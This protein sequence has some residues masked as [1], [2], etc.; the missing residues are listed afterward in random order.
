MHI[1]GRVPVGREGEAE[2]GVGKEED[3]EK[4]REDG[5]E[6]GREEVMEVGKELG[7]E[8]RREEGMEEGREEGRQVGREEGR[9]LGFVWWEERGKGAF[10]ASWVVI[11]CVLKTEATVLLD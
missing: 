8:V 11:T 2:L 10:D 5:R 6:E 9:E 7:R 4:G 1:R 3:R